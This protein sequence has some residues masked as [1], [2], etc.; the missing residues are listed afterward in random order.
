MGEK[1]GVTG[2]EVGWKSPKVGLRAS[3]TF[4]EAILISLPRWGL[5]PL[6]DSIAHI[7][8]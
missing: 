2:A 3:L 4:P 8:L 6:L 1:G 7:S 5:C